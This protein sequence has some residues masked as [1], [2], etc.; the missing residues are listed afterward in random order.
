M[1]RVCKGL[2]FVLS[3]IYLFTLC[4]TP[5]VFA[6]ERQRSPVRDAIASSPEASPPETTLPDGDTSLPEQEADTAATG[7]ELLDWLYEN[8]DVGGTLTLTEDIFLQD[9]SYT[10]YQGAPP[11][12]I[13]T[14]EF[15]IRATRD[16]A[17]ISNSLT[18][19]GSGDG[20]GVLRACTGGKLA[21]SYLTVEA[22]EG[23]AIFQ[24]EGAGFASDNCTIKGDIRYADAP[25]AWRW[26]QGLAVVKPDG[27]AADSMPAS[28]EVLVN[29]NGGTGSWEEIPVTWELEGHEDA[30]KGRQRFT[31]RGTLK[32]M[33]SATA[34]ACTV[35]YDDYPLTFLNVS[36]EKLS[37]GRGY[38]Y[39]FQGKF[40]MPED[41]L[42]IIV[43]QEYSFDGTD[44]RLF[45]EKDFPS[46]NI[47][48]KVKISA[49]DWDTE[50]NPD[51]F[52]RMRWDD[53][54][55][56][57]YSNVMSFAAD[58]LAEG[59]DRGGNRGGGTDITDPPTVPNPDPPEGD[60]S[61]GGGNGLPNPTPD[62]DPPEGDNSGGGNGLPNP[63]P[64]PD[65]PEN[66]KPDLPSDPDQTLPPESKPD[67]SPVR[68]G[69]GGSNGGGS[70]APDRVPDPVP[71][72][73][74]SQMPDPAPSQVSSQT[75]VPAPGPVLNQ[76]P[77]SEPT[78][79]QTS[80]ATMAPAESG[81]SRPKQEEAAEVTPTS[82]P[83]PDTLETAAD[84]AVPSVLPD[85]TDT[86][87][88]SQPIAVP[89]GRSVLPIAAGCA[90][91]AGT[92]GAAALYLHP[93][94]LKK[95]LKLLRAILAKK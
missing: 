75:P 49:R 64:D 47:S 82:E 57:Y 38:I 32:G 95:L 7:E 2:A 23:L 24:E 15:S 58:N 48:F 14:G 20:Q 81:T 78:P 71:S 63:P 8:E 44:W 86:L 80:D 69:N 46:V 91:V 92:I 27:L 67:T 11:I 19:R 93:Q 59:Q 76:S 18:I 40:S 61:D 10:G 51:I 68:P 28:L 16:V 39:Q 60:N 26:K 50:N 36:G 66:G 62:P 72:Q 77:A 13:D 29:R 53:E 79:V 12:T 89:E 94:A 42:P 52:I 87:P 33:M 74:P 54:G 34:P 90:A 45:E 3:I 17:I 31:V 9:V 5:A 6:T 35:V 73:A 22:D 65:P 85:H 30:Q 83:A 21:L 1:N 41:R 4:L 55:T 88:V 70:A 25:F 84:K 56:M 37:G 43:V